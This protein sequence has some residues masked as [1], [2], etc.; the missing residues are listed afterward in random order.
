MKYELVMYENETRSTPDAIHEIIS[1][2]QDY[3]KGDIPFYSYKKAL[4][5]LEVYENKQV[6]ECYYNHHF[7]IAR[8]DNKLLVSYMQDEDNYIDNVIEHYFK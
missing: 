5:Q 3:S 6:E 2:K 1:Q 8:K 4:Q 7:F